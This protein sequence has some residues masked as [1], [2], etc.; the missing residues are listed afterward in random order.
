M[1][2]ARPAVRFTH[3]MTPVPDQTGEVEALRSALAVERGA[4]APG[5]EA[6]TAHFKL[7]I[8]KLRHNK[9]G[10]FSERGRKLIEQLKMELGYLVATVAEDTTRAGGQG[11]ER[12]GVPLPHKSVRGALP[13]YLASERIVV[14]TLAAYPCCGDGPS[15]LAEDVTR[16]LRRC[17][18]PGRRPRPCGLGLQ[19]GPR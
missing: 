9:C 15:K 5:A 19:S 14:P 17:S 10:A 7:V 4:R 18:G 11:G 2:A 16:P 13:A 6:M 12:P 1:L 3:P 8:A